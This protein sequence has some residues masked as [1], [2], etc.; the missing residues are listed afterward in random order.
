MEACRKRP[1][2]RACRAPG[3]T[4]SRMRA[5]WSC[6]RRYVSESAQLLVAEVPSA[7]P[8]RRR[9]LAAHYKLRFRENQREMPRHD[10]RRERVT[11]NAPFSLAPF[12]TAPNRTARTASETDV[13][14]HRLILILRN[15][16]DR[17]GERRQRTV[18]QRLREV[19]VAHLVGVG[20]KNSRVSPVQLLTI[21]YERAIDILHAI[22]LPQERRHTLR[23]HDKRIAIRLD[24][25][26]GKRVRAGPDLPR[27]VVPVLLKR[28]IYLQLI[29]SADAD[30]VAVASSADPRGHVRVNKRG[31]NPLAV[32]PDWIADVR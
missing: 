11:T 4:Q 6:C 5:V 15:N 23:R 17:R 2:T 13:V 28:S 32:V 12:E 29:L 18:E 31:R 14:D 1:Q 16:I 8:H 26:G 3:K 10:A 22:A 20:E 21:L 9:A 25:I 30:H 19:D 27:D 7:Q 24:V